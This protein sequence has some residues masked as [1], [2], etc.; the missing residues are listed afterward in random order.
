LLVPSDP[1]GL[2][3]PIEAVTVENFVTRRGK[4]YFLYLV[5]VESPLPE[6]AWHIHVGFYRAVL[7]TLAGKAHSFTLGTVES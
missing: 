5:T 4:V 3:T 6:K 2:V 1:N 7:T